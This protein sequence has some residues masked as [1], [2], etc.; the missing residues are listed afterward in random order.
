MT[1]APCPEWMRQMSQQDTGSKPRK[2]IKED[3]QM[4]KSGCNMTFNAWKT[5]HPKGYIYFRETSGIPGK[6]L[7]PG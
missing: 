6:L 4:K 2:Q 5:L 1:E 7:T 3:E